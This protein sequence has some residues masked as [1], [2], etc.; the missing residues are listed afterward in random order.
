MVR[1]VF[2]WSPLSTV[3][4]ALAKAIIMFVTGPQ[5]W[6]YYLSTLVV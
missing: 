3:R 6:A 2:G 1:T 4:M 5:S